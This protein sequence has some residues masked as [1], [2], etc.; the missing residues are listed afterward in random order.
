MPD[1]TVIQKNDEGVAFLVQV[2]DQDGN[3]INLSS[4]SSINILFEKP[5]KT[6]VSKTASFVTD[7]TDGQIEYISIT[8]DLNMVGRWQIQASYIKSS[9]LKYTSKDT[10]IVDSNLTS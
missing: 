2:N 9:N 10:F 3:A 4:A 6:F 5:D 7:G 8:G 1:S